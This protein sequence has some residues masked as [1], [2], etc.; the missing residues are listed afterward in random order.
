[1]GANQPTCYLQRARHVALPRLDH[2]SSS[3]ISAVAA[4][5]TSSRI[6]AS[7]PSPMKPSAAFAIGLPDRRIS[8]RR[9]RLDR[10]WS[11]PPQGDLKSM[12]SLE[13]GRVHLHILRGWI[14][15]GRLLKIDAVR[16]R[17]CR[18]ASTPR[19]APGIL[20]AAIAA[21]GPNGRVVV[22]AR[23]MTSNCRRQMAAMFI[24]GMLAS[25]LD[26]PVIPGDVGRAFED[27]PRTHA[28]ATEG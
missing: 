12:A 10:K 7:L 14:G 26:A 1:M 18:C 2:G 11:C 15:F 25:S 5:T 3:T 19:R 4:T 23:S 27:E 21:G 17:A 8:V 24:V 22:L 16:R 20:V 13:Q 28:Q 9:R 6:P